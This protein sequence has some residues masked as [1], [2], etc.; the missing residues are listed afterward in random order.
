M[1]KKKIILDQKSELT[2]CVTN[3]TYCMKLYCHCILGWH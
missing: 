1:Q 3:Q 2:G